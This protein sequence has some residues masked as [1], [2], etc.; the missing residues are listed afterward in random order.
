VTAW[1][2]A[3]VLSVRR[4][5][6]VLAPQPVVFEA[7]RVASVAQHAALPEG[8]VMRVALPTG[9]AAVAQQGVAAVVAE[10]PS[11][12]GVVVAEPVVRLGVAERSVLQVVQLSVR[13]FA[14]HRTCVSFRLPHWLGRQPSERF[15]R[16][17]AW[18]LSAAP[19][20]PWWRAE[21]DEVLSSQYLS[22]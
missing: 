18:P 5:V 7:A 2:A 14:A 6:V 13:A 4:L 10:E 3:A 15:V 12:G 1:A 22:R 8:A 19:R 11:A 16:E 17:P 21:S 20:S 9:A